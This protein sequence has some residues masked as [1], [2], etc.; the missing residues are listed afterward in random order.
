MSCP[1]FNALICNSESYYLSDIRYQVGFKFW[2]NRKHK[3]TSQF[4]HEKQKNNTFLCCM[5]KESR[6]WSLLSYNWVDKVV[7]VCN[8]VRTNMWTRDNDYIIEWMR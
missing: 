8:E 3:F 7:I 4:C 2:E 1:Q 5:N 6:Y